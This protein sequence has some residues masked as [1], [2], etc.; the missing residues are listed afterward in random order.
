[1]MGFFS[2]PD[3]QQHG[4]GEATSS[5]TESLFGK[6]KKRRKSKN[7]DNNDTAS[8]VTLT[9]ER[10]QELWE[11]SEDRHVLQTKIHRMEL[12]ITQLNQNQNATQTKLE[13]VHQVAISLIQATVSTAVLLFALLVYTLWLLVPNRSEQTAI[14]DASVLSGSF[15]VMTVVFVVFAVKFSRL[16]S[17]FLTRDGVVDEDDDD[18]TFSVSSA[19]MSM[20]NLSPS[21]RGQDLLLSGERKGV[22]GR[23]STNL[24]QPLLSA[25]KVA[26][27]R[28]HDGSSS[29]SIQQRQST[30]LPPPKE[31]PHRPVLLCINTPTDVSLTVDPLYGQGAC[32]IGKPFWFS[33]DLFEGYCLVRIKNVPNS[34]D[35]EGDVAYFDGRRRLF[36][37][38]VQGRF[39]EPLPVNTVLTGHE[40]TK[41]LKNLPHQWILKAATNLIRRLAPGS[42]ICVVGDRPTMLAPLAGTSQ[43]VR[44]DEKGKEP[45][46]SSIEGVEEDCSLMGGKFLESSVSSSFRKKYLA[47]PKKSSRYRFDTELVY[48]FDFYQNLL[49]VTTYKLDLG[50]T[51]ISMCP[52]LNGQPIQCLAKT[53]DGR[54]LWSFQVWHESLLPER[55]NLDGHR[56]KKQ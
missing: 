13:I 45:D 5:L 19:S 4:G 27:F 33:S 6:K 41:P 44:V 9:T 39:K 29:R 35:P 3:S 25:T 22:I 47:N 40:F 2:K 37:T 18:D 24:F 30:D 32:P 52:I 36:Q 10:F 7:H 54:Y 26:K 34:D 23:R 49:N 55:K 43:V 8:V 12:A 20:S 17:V 56:K 50:I 42:E 48:T 1:M 28:E 14:A 15:I 16:F 53:T 21:S 11:A 51:S 38:I 31:W 46:L